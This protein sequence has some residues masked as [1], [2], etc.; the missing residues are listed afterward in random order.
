MDQ[1][2]L[3]KLCPLTTSSKR[4][5]QVSSRVSKLECQVTRKVLR[6]TIEIK[7]T[8]SSNQ[9][10]PLLVQLTICNQRPQLPDQCPKLPMV[11]QSSPPLL[12]SSFSKTKQT[13][14]VKS[15]QETDNTLHNSNIRMA[16]LLIL[17]KIKTRKIH[18][19][20]ELNLQQVTPLT[21]VCL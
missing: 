14:S 13:I 4:M 16:E 20:R 11:L 21:E 9:I 12:L 3:G 17:L 6:N 18:L 8:N 19:L 1:T 2:C 10:K 7:L 5:V 15:Q